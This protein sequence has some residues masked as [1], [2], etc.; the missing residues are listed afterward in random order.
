MS[1]NGD[2]LFV[3]ILFGSREGNDLSCS[4]N[5]SAFIYVVHSS[6][7]Q[8]MSSPLSASTQP[9]TRMILVG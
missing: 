4:F 2:C 8:D 1:Y 5:A 9:K 6:E 7:C 3:L